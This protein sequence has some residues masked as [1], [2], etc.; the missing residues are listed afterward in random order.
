[1]TKQKPHR[2]I[3]I[4]WS[5]QTGLF[6]RHFYNPLHQGKENKQHNHIRSHRITPFLPSTNQDEP[7]DQRHH[8]HIG[9]KLTF[10]QHKTSILLE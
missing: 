4:R 8:H 10:A 2:I 9:E 6:S 1:M 3:A 7:H 5:N